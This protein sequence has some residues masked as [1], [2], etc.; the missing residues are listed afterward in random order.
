[1][2]REQKAREAEQWDEERE[3]LG[4]RKY[5]DEEERGWKIRKE[6]SERGEGQVRETSNRRRRPGN[7][8]SWMVQREHI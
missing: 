7:A 1:M 3:G 4:R 5:G 2:G 6:G 8:G